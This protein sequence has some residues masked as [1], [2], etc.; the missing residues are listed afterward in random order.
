MSYGQTELIHTIRRC[1]LT[2]GLKVCLDAGDANSYPSGESWLDTSGNGYDF[3]RGATGAGG[4]ASD[5]TFNG[6]AGQRSSGEYWSF[7][8]GD[9]FRYDTTNETWMQN[10]HKDNAKFT[11]IAGVQHGGTG[12]KS[13]L[14][15][16]GTGTGSAIGVNW[17]ILAGNEL[18]FAVRAGATGV[19]SDTSTLTPTEDVPSFVAVSLDEAVGASGGFHYLNGVVDTFTSTYTSPSASNA[20][21]T[22][23]LGARGNGESPLLSTSR[24]WFFAAW[25]SVALSQEQVNALYMGTRGRMGI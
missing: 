17:H 22:L 8:G 4:E 24:L 5:P 23:E 1:G 25:E 13:G 15:G 18:I 16:T 12:A 10:L 20:T 7:D 21:Y 19:F 14:C 2:T 11:F 6:T 3:F 9:Y